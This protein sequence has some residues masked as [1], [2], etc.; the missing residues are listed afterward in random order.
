MVDI[1]E[2][3]KGGGF[4]SEERR[5][6]CDLW[7]RSSQHFHKIFINPIV[8]TEYKTTL[9]VNVEVVASSKGL[10][11]LDFGEVV[12]FCVS[13]PL[14]GAH[15]L[16]PYPK[17]TKDYRTR[18]GNAC[19]AV[20][21]PISDQYKLVTIGLLDGKERGYKFQV[22]SSEGSD[23][24]WRK[25]KLRMDLI[26]NTFSNFLSCT[27]VYVNDS[28]HWLRNDGRVVSFITKREEA[29]ILDLPE[30]IV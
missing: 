29:T 12:G 3:Q 15:Q 5:R 28:V 14:T 18:I 30:F 13:N 11:L 17:P 7:H 27:P 26:R 25:F 9:P 19:L 24:M 6:Y 20:D 8:T 21:Y 23:G 2:F 1:R 22:F 16:I 4:A 10:L